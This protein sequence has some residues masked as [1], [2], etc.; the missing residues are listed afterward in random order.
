MYSNKP[1]RNADGTV[2]IGAEFT[3]GDLPV[4][5]IMPDRRWFGNTRVIEQKA[6]ETFRTEIDKARSDPYT[7]VLHESKLPYGL[8]S[9]PKRAASVNL[10]DAEPFDATFGPN[11]QRKRVKLTAHDV[12]SLVSEVEARESTYDPLAD[13]IATPVAFRSLRRED[14]FEKGTSKRI[15]GEL[16]KVLDSSDVIVQV[17]D[18][19]D[20]MGTRS[21]QVED[22]LRNNARHK[23]LIFVLNKCDLVPTWATARWV[24]LLSQEYPTLAFHASLG[25]PFGKGS[26]INLLRQFSHLHAER[27]QI[28]VGFIGYPNVG[29]SS[30][31]NTLRK[32][33]VCKAGPVPG[34]TKIWQYITLMKRIFL[35]DCP[36]IVVPTGATETDLLLRGVV[37]VEKVEDLVQHIDELLARVRRDHLVRTY[38]ISEWDDAEDFLEKI[39]RRSGRLLKGGEPDLNS[40]AKAVIRDWQRGKL[41]H[42]I[43]PPFEDDVE[44]QEAEARMK[45]AADEAER[46]AKIAA[47]LPGVPVQFGEDPLGDAME[48]RQ[49]R[50]TQAHATTKR[51]RDAL[52]TDDVGDTGAAHDGE[53]DDAAADAGDDDDAG[54]AGDAAAASADDSE[55]DSDEINMRVQTGQLDVPKQNLRKIPVAEIFRDEDFGSGMAPPQQAPLALQFD[56]DDDG[57]VDWDLVYRERDVDGD[58]ELGPRPTADWGAEGPPAD[59]VHRDQTSRKSLTRKQR[60]NARVKKERAKAGAGDS[61]GS[62]DNDND[63]NNS[64]AAAANDDASVSV[65]IDMTEATPEQIAR[66]QRIEARAR[67]DARRQE[68]LAELAARKSAPV[69]Q[70][71]QSAESSSVK[72]SSSSKKTVEQLKAILA[73][74]EER[75]VEEA[76]RKKLSMRKKRSAGEI[77]EPTDKGN[78]LLLRSNQEQP[79]KLPRLTTNKGKIGVHYYEEVNVKNRKRSAAH[80]NRKRT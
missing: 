1:I 68:R 73:A 3:S 71:Q 43:V 6:L 35:I 28:T 64:A 2:K 51:K 50:D 7:V 74:T 11:K 22:H 44:K 67:R 20:P 53:H 5:R 75:Q 55:L 17:L 69:Q 52:E 45:A 8:L 15:W 38:S 80:P 46:R 59:L 58:V 49:R 9:D 14:V 56:D 66:R 26:L 12:S 79:A 65:S 34:E 29:K 21:K 47:Q 57:A 30:I 37:R 32:K 70:Q 13:R 78:S 76:E 72:V 23:H 60:R 25:K 33:I 61:A 41:P 54:D 36:G 4:A 10:T 40:V 16:Y 27:P 48:K 77:E 18:A 31:I 63:K 42:F 39:A 24:K 62:D 19:R